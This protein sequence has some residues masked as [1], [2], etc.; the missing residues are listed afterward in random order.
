MIDREQKQSG[1]LSVVSLVGEAISLA[2]CCRGPFRWPIVGELLPSTGV[3]ANY[4]QFC[5]VGKIWCLQNPLQSFRQ[6]YCNRGG[7]RNTL[8]QTPNIIFKPLRCIDQ[9]FMSSGLMVILR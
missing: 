3:K 7:L 1:L 9:S 2:S 4:S 6:T 8:E 5:S